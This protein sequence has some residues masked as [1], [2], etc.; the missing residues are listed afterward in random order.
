MAR[1]ARSMLEA[2]KSPEEILLACYGVPFPVEVFI[3]AEMEADDV[4]PSF[5]LMTPWELITPLARGGPR[6][7]LPHRD[8][9]EK[10]VA[11]LDPSLIVLTRLYGRRQ[12]AC[13]R[14][15][16]LA[17]GRS[18]V[19]GL[20]DDLK[21]GSVAQQLG[22][23]LGSVMLELA[24]EALHSAEAEYSSPGNRGAGSIDD[25]EVESVRQNLVR[26]EDWVALTT[27][28]L[29]GKV[30]PKSELPWNQR[31]RAKDLIGAA[32]AGDVAKLR[33]LVAEGAILDPPGEDTALFAAI[34]NS[35]LEAARFLLDARA[36]LHH[37]GQYSGLGPLVRAC[38]SSSIE[39]IEFVIDRGAS[40]KE[41]DAI[42]TA[43]HL[44][45]KVQGR[46]ILALLVKR[47]IDPN[48][49]CTSASIL[50]AVCKVGDVDLA[51]ELL[52]RG[53]DPNF[54]H[55]Y[56]TALLV[57]EEHGHQV[58]VDLLLD[59][60][61]VPDW[62]AVAPDP[63]GDAIWAAAR[64]NPN[65]PQLRLDWAAVLLR[66]GMRAAAARE[67]Q[68]VEKMAASVDTLRDSL[69]LEHPQG[70]WWTFAPFE[71]AINDVTSPIEDTRFPGARLTSGDQTLPLAVL[72]GPPCGTCDEKGQTVCSEC[73]GTGLGDNYMTGG[74]FKCEPRQTCT[75]C[76]GL[77]YVVRSRAYGKGSCK[78]KTIVAEQ[79]LPRTQSTTFLLELT[80]RR[81]AD[82]GLPALNDEF[83][84]GVCGFFVCRCTFER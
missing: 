34:E 75:S 67:A 3:V 9:D 7:E 59:R 76:R 35:R 24:R 32:E 44:N 47:G 78:H 68:A 49:Q 26:V 37:R 19:F 77:K 12:F 74:T 64:A 27:E 23:S 46:R 50:T 56:G 31:A 70:K 18:T 45:D 16:E 11:E 21:D 36:N 5:S 65:H 57:A 52:D 72:L 66:R 83:A 25:E 15:D 69:K 79:A 53:A 30:R 84:C 61:A 60:G 51:R 43:L 17:A 14:R 71:A 28:R 81:C 73:N 4:E 6:A 58:L 42:S 20:P 40:L 29:A 22:A 41:W 55:F 80:M 13:Y 54:R 10:R 1:L 62:P 39:M 48:A 82:C 2:G 38:R 33:T 63:E 8:K